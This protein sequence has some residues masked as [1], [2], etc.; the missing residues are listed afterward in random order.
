[1]R[2][3]MLYADC[4]DSCLNE[5]EPFDFIVNAIIPP[6]PSNPKE[7]ISTLMS[8]SRSVKPAWLLLDVAFMM[9]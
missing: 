6:I 9:A 2:S 1:M 4:T 3:M 8:S 7:R 5:L